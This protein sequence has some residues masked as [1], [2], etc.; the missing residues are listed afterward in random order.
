MAAFGSA[1]PVTTGQSEV[2]PG[3]RPG[4]SAAFSPGR[5]RPELDRRPLDG[6]PTPGLT[7]T[8]RPENELGRRHC[9]ITG[10]D[11]RSRELRRVPGTGDRHSRCRTGSAGRQTGDHRCPD[12]G[13]EQLSGRCVEQ[14][15]ARIRLACRPTVPGRRPV[16]ATTATIRPPEQQQPHHNGRHQQHCAIDDP[17]GIG[18]GEQGDPPPGEH[19]DGGCRTRQRSTQYGECYERAEQLDPCASNRAGNRGR[20]RAGR[21]TMRDAVVRPS[22]ASIATYRH[23]T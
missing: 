12:D 10:T 18:A 15:G 14:P 8:D 9:P 1:A 20:T 19:G 4:R 2:Q 13:H 7:C 11:R 6:D 17:G 3:G 23:K 16:I 22:F 21:A 5:G